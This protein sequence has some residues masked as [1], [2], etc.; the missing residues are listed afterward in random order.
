MCLGRFDT[1]LTIQSP[2]AAAAAKFSM[3]LAKA[4]LRTET[5]RAFSAEEAAGFLG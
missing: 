3:F 5:R 2:D 1:I 4:G